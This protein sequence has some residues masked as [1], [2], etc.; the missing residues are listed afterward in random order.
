MLLDQF[1]DTLVEILLAAAVVSFILA[2]VRSR[3]GGRRDH[4]CV[5]PL[6]ILLILLLNAC[7]GVWRESSA[8]CALEALQDTQ[9]TRQ[10]LWCETGTR[11]SVLKATNQALTRGWATRQRLWCETGTRV[12]VLK[13]TN[14]ALTRGWVSTSLVCP[15]SHAAPSQGRNG[16]DGGRGG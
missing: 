8:E 13:A 7:V 11:V 1:N 9:A 12:S 2:C 5:E 6:I 14:Q 4:P 3:S 15:H 16:E 10:R